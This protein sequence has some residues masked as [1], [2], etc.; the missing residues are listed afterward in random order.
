MSHSANALNDIGN[1]IMRSSPE[2]APSS[3]SE[4]SG[5]SLIFGWRVHSANLRH[6]AELSNRPYF[7]T[8]SKPTLVFLRLVQ[9]LRVE[10]RLRLVNQAARPSA[11]VI[12]LPVEL[13]DVIIEHYLQVEVD[14]NLEE[15]GS[16]RSWCD[17]CLHHHTCHCGCHD[18]VL[19]EDCDEGI[20]GNGKQCRFCSGTGELENEELEDNLRCSCHE[21]D[22]HDHATDGHAEVH[23]G[24]DGKVSG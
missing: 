11:S 7:W 19:C 4:G 13:W 20:G 12:D 21:H 22:E 9:K 1:T 8:H 3:G 2:I 17:Q 6:A 5:S 15:I 18:L 10:G 23:F 16:L 14:P 24:F